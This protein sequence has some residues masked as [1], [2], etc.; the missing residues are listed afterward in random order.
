MTFKKLRS[1]Q[2]QWA[3][4]AELFYFQPSISVCIWNDSR[5]ESWQGTCNQSSKCILPLESGWQLVQ[6]VQLGISSFTGL[7]LALSLGIQ[8]PQCP[9]WPWQQRVLAPLEMQPRG[10]LLFL[11]GVISVSKKWSANSPGSIKSRDWRN[12][13]LCRVQRK[14]ASAE[15]KPL[16]RQVDSGGSGEGRSTVARDPWQGREAG[17]V[18]GILLS[19]V[20]RDPPEALLVRLGEQ[21]ENVEIIQ[22]HPYRRGRITSPLPPQRRRE[23]P[24]EE[25]YP[26]ASFLVGFSEDL[27]CCLVIRCLSC[28]PPLSD[29]ASPEG[30]TQSGRGNPLNLRPGAEIA[31]ILVCTRAVLWKCFII[32]SCTFIIWIRLRVIIRKSH[33]V[34]YII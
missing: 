25:L 7:S 26:A 17:R 13:C 10:R 9:C 5:K 27:G 20:G 31:H 19:W 2:V 28:L 34:T 3:E 12:N 8:W 23:G 32:S 6:P 30:F 16:A 15:W 11:G 18:K 14:D 21:R 24:S 4:K 1:Y 22:Q 29:S 33:K